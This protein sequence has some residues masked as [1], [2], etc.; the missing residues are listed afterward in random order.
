MKYKVTITVEAEDSEG[1]IDQAVRAADM[2]QQLRGNHA[3]ACQQF[4]R[5]VEYQG[6]SLH[7]IE[8][9]ASKCPTSQKP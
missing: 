4:R 6:P 3:V 7:G 8:R 9:E 2:F 5:T 1:L